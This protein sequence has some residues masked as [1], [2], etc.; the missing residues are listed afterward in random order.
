MPWQRHVA[1]VA[2]EVNPA[3]GL[4]AYRRVVLTVPRQ[5]GKTTLILALVLTRALAW[6]SPQ[7][8]AYTAQTGSDARAKWQDDWLPIIEA[9]PYQRQL[10]NGRPRL[11]NGHEALVFVNG[12][13]QTL[14]AGTKKSGHGKTLDLGLVDEAFAQHD[15]RVEQSYSAPMITRA[16]P[17]LWIVSTAGVPG[18]S[19]YLWQQVEAGRQAAELGLT[20]GTAYF[21]W[22]ADEK[23][24]PAD[25]ATWWSCMPALGYT[26]TEEAVRAEFQSWP[27]QEFRRAYLNQ[28]VEGKTD[29]VISGDQWQ[30]AIVPGASAKG[31]RVAFTIDVS[32][33]R[34]TASIAAAGGSDDRPVLHI[35]DN[36]PGTGWI[37]PRLV[38]LR[39]S[40][41]PYALAL[42]GG[43]AAASLLPDL[44]RAGFV[45]KKKPDGS[46]AHGSLIVIG[47][48]DY[49]RACG[50]FYDAVVPGHELV[51]ADDGTEQKVPL[52]SRVAHAGQAVLAA[53]VENATK[54]KLGDAWAWNRQSAT[55][56][57]TP[58]VA[59][60]I[61]LW[62]HRQHRPPAPR[63]RF[64]DVAAAWQRAQQERT[65][66]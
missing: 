53:A 25:P 33:D 9:S 26:V 1:D 42:D 51:V 14:G 46:Y 66:T 61:A 34:S 49:A 15:D 64:P 30:A 6:S 36:R 10:R 35:T 7:K 63:V 17:Q 32:P 19:P 39:D 20:E 47:A 4:L 52:P 40:H 60:T 58:L 29:P 27:R 12:S 41:R 5:S 50:F 3:T 11:T 23:A 65:P 55:A 16:E 21:E 31:D 45:E 13:I 28:W 56:D 57:I 59:A 44:Q 38:E 22:S 48:L 54:R 37:V 8:I 18:E 62:I 43:A 2:L 24:D